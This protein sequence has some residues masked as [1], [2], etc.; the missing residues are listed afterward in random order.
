MHN[1]RK[2][3]DASRAL[4]YTAYD[5]AVHAREFDSRAGK[6]KEFMHEGITLIRPLNRELLV[7]GRHANIAAQ[8]A[9][10]AWVLTGWNSISDIEPYLPRAAEFS[11]D[12]ETWRAGYGPRIRSWNRRG[13]VDQ[14]AEVVELLKDD[15][16]TRRAVMSIWDPAEDFVSSK[17]IPCNNWLSFSIRDGLLDLH[18][19][20]RSN[21]IIWG[22]SGVN[23]FE[24]SVLQEITA[25]MVGVEV[26]ALHFS[27]TSLHIY[28]RHWEKA[29]NYKVLED[30]HL[31]ESPRFEGAHLSVGEFTDLMVRWWG[32]ERKIRAGKTM[33]TEIAAFPEP[34]L[35][36]WLQVIAWYWSGNTSWLDSL[37][38]TRLYEACML[39]PK[40]RTLPIETVGAWAGEDPHPE[41]RA[42]LKKPVSPFLNYVFDLHLEK[43]EAYGDS[44]KRRGEMLGIMAN[45]ARKID[46][47]GGT[48]TADETSA[49]TAIDLMVYLAKYETWLHPTQDADNPR[50][51]NK[52]L[53]MVEA[54]EPARLIDS[55]APEQ[56]LSDEFDLL[57]RM[58]VDGDE[59]RLWQVDKMLYVSYL[60][61]KDRWEAEQ[62][63]TKVIDPSYAGA[64]AD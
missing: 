26:G 59:N 14:W 27:V 61:A 51:A 44:W 3:L 10:T 62:D 29:E 25:Q 63:P 11:D 13:G 40:Q 15:H 24:W 17:D 58:V 23:Q 9:E 55:I 6:T 45:V 18:V 20:I 22:W 2:Y 36:S 37:R 5:L 7:E 57:E 35:R 33:G 50:D 48:E 56:W 38:G 52:L 42:S 54:A 30:K 28:E 49:D 16:T 47:L 34:M 31:K 1:N 39:T 19:A 64:D 46:R 4:V 41:F 8:I 32:L 53:A 43:H 21:D 12:G 60:L